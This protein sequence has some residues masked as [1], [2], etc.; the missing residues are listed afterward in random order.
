MKK[1]IKRFPWWIIGMFILIGI[2]FVLSE[3][4]RLPW[5]IIVSCAPIIGLII[6]FAFVTVKVNLEE[7]K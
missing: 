6:D 1:F 4:L 5:L 3:V 7:L 2:C